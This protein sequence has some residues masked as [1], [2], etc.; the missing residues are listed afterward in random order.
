VDAR[1]RAVESL[2]A[3]CHPSVADQLLQLSGKLKEPA[4]LAAVYRGLAKQESSAAK[5]APKVTKL[6]LAEAKRERD[7]MER[8]DPGFPID[9]KTGAAAEGTPEAKQA[10]NDTRERGMMLVEALRCLGALG[11]R[12]SEDADAFAVFLQDPYDD[13]VVE[14]LRFLA[15]HRD[16]RAL[17]A[18]LLLHRMYPSPTA[19]ET[20]FIVK[21][22]GMSAEG[23]QEW[24]VLFGHPWKSRTRPD[25]VAALREA[26]ERITGE[27]LET[28]RA[29]EQYLERPEVKARLGG[30]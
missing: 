20:D 10:L 12:G 13:L 7:R 19:M 5:V 30:R 14:T 24:L 8:G 26:V 22:H 28:P 15:H 21:E 3:L 9:P 29:L 16:V 1:L 17:P 23:R 2:G 25:V 6:L 27:R 4:L 11:A 18:M